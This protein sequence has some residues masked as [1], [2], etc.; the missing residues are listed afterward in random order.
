MSCRAH[1]YHRSSY[2][3][4]AVSSTPRR[5]G[6]TAGVPVKPGDDSCR[7]S[8]LKLVRAGIDDFPELFAV[9]DL[10]HFGGQP[11]VAADPVLHR[12]RIIGHQVGSPVGARDLD[13]EGNSLG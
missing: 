6:S 9:L 1:H 11:A 2:P 3:A 13:P 7:C 12:I 8:A 10:L 4:K 5:L